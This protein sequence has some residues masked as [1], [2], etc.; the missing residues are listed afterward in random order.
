MA[1]YSSPRMELPG[2]GQGSGCRPRWAEPSRTEGGSRGGSE[3]FTASTVRSEGALVAFPYRSGK[4]MREGNR[5]NRD[6]DAPIPGRAGKQSRRKW[7]PIKQA[8]I[9]AFGRKR[10]RQ[11]N[12]RE[13]EQIPPIPARICNGIPGFPRYFA[14]NRVDRRS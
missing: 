12:H 1:T 8:A 3:G 10:K 11:V 6:T 9:D 7:Q 14:M 4:A 5:R 2:S 13:A